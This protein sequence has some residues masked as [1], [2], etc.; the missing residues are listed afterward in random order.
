VNRLE[1]KQF[2]EQLNAE[3]INA[4]SVVVTHYRGLTVS[5]ITNLR[6][7]LMKNNVKFKVTKNLLT[8]IALKGTAFEHLM[9]G[10]TG[11]TAI[12]YS[13]DPI[14]PAKGLMEFAKS[15]ETLVILKGSLDGQLLN[16][17]GVMALAN[18]PSLDELRGKLVGLLVAPAQKIA[19]VTQAPAS[20]L[21]RLIKAHSE[22]NS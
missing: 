20:Q 21:A 18:L 3:L 8:R 4:K 9:D 7:S 1:K 13:N 22:K 19:C 15:N 17:S 5:E 10:F 14:A 11:P 12:A 2:V 6:K 16:K